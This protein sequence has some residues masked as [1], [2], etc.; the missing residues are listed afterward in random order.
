MGNRGKESNQAAP[1]MTDDLAVLREFRA[2][3]SNDLMVASDSKH[4]HGTPS[5]HTFDFTADPLE[6]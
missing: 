4:T 6:T 1:E 5:L 2:P 3:G